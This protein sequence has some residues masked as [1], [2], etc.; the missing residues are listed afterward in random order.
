VAE[1]PSTI[2]IKDAE[3]ALTLPPRPEDVIH[4]LILDDGW[5]YKVR[6]R[7]GQGTGRMSHLKTIKQK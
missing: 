6:G 2:N 5:G 7:K 1:R 3:L 4:S